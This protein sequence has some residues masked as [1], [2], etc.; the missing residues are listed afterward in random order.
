LGGKGGFGTLL[1]IQSKKAG[2]KTTLDFGAC[3]DLNGR[4]LRHVNDEIK[5]R[6]WRSNLNN[7]GEEEENVAGWHLDLPGWARNE[8]GSEKVRKRNEMKFRRERQREEEEREIKKRK[9]EAEVLKREQLVMDYADKPI[10]D[11]YSNEGGM[12]NAIKQGLKKRMKV[13]EDVSTK[14]IPN[15]LESIQ[16]NNAN[17][18][19]ALAGDIHT[20]FLSTDSQSNNK[21]PSGTYNSFN[22]TTYIVGKSEFSTVCVLRPNLHYFEVKLETCGLSQ[23]GFADISS[24]ANFA[25]NTDTGDGVGDDE[26]SY[27]FDISRNK[28][29]HNYKEFKYPNAQKKKTGAFDDMNQPGNVI[30]C[31]YNHLTDEISFFLNG[32]DLGV[33]FSIK[34][35]RKKSPGMQMI[36]AISLN[37]DEVIGL[38]IGPYFQFNPCVKTSLEPV[39]DMETA[40]Q[41]D[42]KHISSSPSN[43]Q[44]VEPSGE[45]AATNVLKNSEAIEIKKPA[46]TIP[47]HLDLS[48]YDSAESLRVLGL[49]RL[50]SALLALSVKCG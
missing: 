43:S 29:F 32:E 31:W 39:R 37:Q 38:R 36:P 7:S 45:D 24:S 33:A 10:N 26:F 8:A 23:I 22:P 19:C 6:K 2:A 34:E 5:L 46:P 47:E 35:K 16:D 17:W 3:R 30:G 44:S 14:N 49:E 21:R 48:H 1:K 12:E 20:T 18:F 42:I 41:P 13:E 28:V 11:P 25:P 27:A 9:K 40:K 50:K 4:R 15:E